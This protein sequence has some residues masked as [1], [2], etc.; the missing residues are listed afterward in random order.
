MP[1]GRSAR[2]TSRLPPPRRGESRQYLLTSFAF[3][4]DAPAK[5]SP[6]A[7]LEHTLPPDCLPYQAGIAAVTVD[8][9][10]RAGRHFRPGEFTIMVVGPGEGMDKPLS[11]YGTVNTVDITLPPDPGEK[12]ESPP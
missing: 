5:V 9:V 12:G 6:P 1:R 8:E 11:S 7:P 10:R 3:L 2:A 4:F